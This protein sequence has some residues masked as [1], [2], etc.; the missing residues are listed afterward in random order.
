MR[1]TS[2]S[3]FTKVKKIMCCVFQ[4]AFWCC[5]H[6]KAGQNTFLGCFKPF[7]FISNIFQVFSSEIKKN[8]Y[9]SLKKLRFKLLF[10][11]GRHAN[12]GQLPE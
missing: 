8:V 1:F 9:K 4:P 5:M 2:K 12:A 7:L 11:T 6:P 10:K 3:L